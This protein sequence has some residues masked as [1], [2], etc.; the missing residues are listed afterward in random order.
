MT[1]SRNIDLENL[2]DCDRMF[3]RSMINKHNAGDTP[4]ATSYNLKYFK[5]LYV[6]MCIR[7]SLPDLKPEFREIAEAM[8]E[9]I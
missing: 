3:L 1:K 8:I 2:S 6:R 9:V 7:K 4:C 5:P